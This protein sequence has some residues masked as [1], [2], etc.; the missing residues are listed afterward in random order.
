MIFSRPAGERFEEFDSCTIEQRLMDINGVPHD[1]IL[2]EVTAYPEKEWLEL[3]ADWESHDFYKDDPEGR[4]AN[5]ARKE[6]CKITYQAPFTN[7]ISN[8]RNKTRTSR[9]LRRNKQSLRK[10]SLLALR[11]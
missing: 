1:Y 5:L 9:R 7:G 3:K 6:A 8:K 4:E 11:A 2:V 10:V